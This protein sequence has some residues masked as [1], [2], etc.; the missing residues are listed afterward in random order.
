M[1]DTETIDAELRLLAR[2]WRVA[3]ELCDP[4]P[5]TAHIDELLDERSAT[6]LLKNKVAPR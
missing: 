2:A 3:C 1:R 4:M 5:S 6:V